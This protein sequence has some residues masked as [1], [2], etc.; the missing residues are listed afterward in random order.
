MGRLL[1][2][3]RVREG[4][5]QPDV[6]KILNVSTTTYCGKESGKVEFNRKELLKLKKI[7]GLSDIEFCQIFFCDEE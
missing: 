2:S 5:T 4:L 3:I 6:A 1:K 7:F